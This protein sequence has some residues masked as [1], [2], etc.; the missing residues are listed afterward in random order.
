MILTKNTAHE[1]QGLARLIDQFRNLP[2][3]RGILASWLR[4]V[5]RFENCLFEVLE[6]RDP[7][8]AT[9]VQLDNLGLL[10]G[11]F[12]NGQGDTEF[13]TRILLRVRINRSQGRPEDVIAIL[14]SLGG[15]YEYEEKYPASFRV[16]SF[17]SGDIDRPLIEALRLVKPAGVAFEFQGNSEGLLD[18]AI[19]FDHTS[20]FITAYANGGFAHTSGTQADNYPVHVVRF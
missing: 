4:G 14:A 3:T 15:A 13:R 2:V 12:R 10:V 9:G 11:V 18:H 16:Y 19:Q 20:P 6:A 7:L 5:Q 8:T 17:S 1:E